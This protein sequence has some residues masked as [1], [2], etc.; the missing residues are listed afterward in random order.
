M[1][2]IQQENAHLH[3]T[4]I[5]FMLVLYLLNWNLFWRQSAKFLMKHHYDID[6][7]LA[8]KTFSKKKKKK[9]L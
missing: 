3:S 2:G 5:A 4:N 1:N 8:I 6:T 7:K 9:S